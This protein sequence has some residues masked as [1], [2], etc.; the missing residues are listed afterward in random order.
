VAT[1]IQVSIT[2]DVE[3]GGTDA[4]MLDAYRRLLAIGEFPTKG[5]VLTIECGDQDAQGI[6]DEIAVALTDRALGIDVKI[7]RTQEEEVDRRRMV[8]VSS[9]PTA[10]PMERVWRG[11]DGT[12]AA[13]QVIDDFAA[14]HDAR[15]VVGNFGRESE[16]WGHEGP[17]S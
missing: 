1:K 3:H 8:A 17:E 11:G 6:R 14:K 12:A 10:T 9:V 2:K 16:G 13:R 4:G 15:V 7:K 5:L